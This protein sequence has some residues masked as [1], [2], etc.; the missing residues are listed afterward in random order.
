MSPV[1]PALQAD[2]LPTEPPENPDMCI[3]NSNTTWYF[4]NY[5]VL[6]KDKGLLKYKI[7]NIGFIQQIWLWHFMIINHY[8]NTYKSSIFHVFRNIKEPT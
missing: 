3:V 6:H 8:V 4:L 7:Y 2:S 1:S 5:S